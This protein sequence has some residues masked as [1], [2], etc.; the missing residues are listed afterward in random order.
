MKRPNVITR[1]V[2]VY[3]DGDEFVVERADGTYTV[4][5]TSNDVVKAV[6]TDDAKISKR[7]KVI[8]VTRLIWRDAF[9]TTDKGAS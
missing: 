2:S 5:L 8:V 9:I 1:D 3:L 6:K 4:A 7:A